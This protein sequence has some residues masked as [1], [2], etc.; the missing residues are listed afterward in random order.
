MSVRIESVRTAAGWHGRII[1]ANGETVWTTE[2]YEDGR[3]VVR[4]VELLA[5]LVDTD[6]GRTVNRWLPM[7]D[8]RTDAHD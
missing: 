7:V 3:R 2:V 1:A 5:D 8:E 6:G 4:A